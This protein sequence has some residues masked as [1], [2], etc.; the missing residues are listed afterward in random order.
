M[1][2]LE[3]LRASMD[4]M[5]RSQGRIEF[6]PDGT[7]I[8]ANENFLK[9]A[10]YTLKELQGAHHSM[11]CDP[12]YSRSAEYKEFWRALSNGEFREG[13][14]PRRNKRGE[15]FWIRGA[16][17]PVMDGSGNV[18]KVLKLATDATEEHQKRLEEARLNAALQSVS[19]NILMCDTDLNINYVNPAV[20]SLFSKYADDMRK[21]FPGCDPNNLIGHN[22]DQFHTDPA[23][24]RAMLRDPRRLPATSQLKVGGAELEVNGNMIKGPNGEDL[25]NVVEWKDITAVMT[26]A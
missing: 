1:K 15:E 9:L 26:I 23:H 25:G 18:V 16:Y 7:I 10:G 14:F 2:E 17:N 5:D 21:R 3:E 24:Q 6:N 4:A 12:E 19:T 22:I 20:A 8:T 11:L 13:L